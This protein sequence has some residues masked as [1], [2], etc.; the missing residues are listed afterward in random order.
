MATI[1]I[2]EDDPAVRDIMRIVVERLG[3]EVLSAA[4]GDEAFALA[5]AHSPDVVLSDVSMPGRTGLELLRDLAADRRF[6]HVPV[7]LTS[8]LTDTLVTSAPAFRFIPKPFRLADIEESIAD[9]LV[10]SDL[11]PTVMTAA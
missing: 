4:D 11:A 8:A 7:V 6:A 2:A 5:V 9:A 1:L 10:H 3:H